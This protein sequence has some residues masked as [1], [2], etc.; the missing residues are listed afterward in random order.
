M[1]LIVHFGPVQFSL[2][3]NL[4][5]GKPKIDYAEIQL[6]LLRDLGPQRHARAD[7]FIVRS[8]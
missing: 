6:S 8:G 1:D 3:R 5:Q 2:G 4:A 7:Y